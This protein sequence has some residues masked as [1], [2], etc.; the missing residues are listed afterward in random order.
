MH[1]RTR[2]RW[3]GIF[4]KL[5]AVGFLAAFIPWIALILLDAPILAPGGRLAP[6]LRFQPYNAP[7]EAMMAAV[8]IVWAVMLWRAAS[9]PEQ[10]TLFLDFTIWATLAHGLVM[11]IATPLQKGVGM[12]AIES[13]PLLVIAGLLWWLRPGAG[14]HRIPK[15]VDMKDYTP[16][17][18][19]GVQEVKGFCP[20][21]EKY[22]KEQLAARTI[23]VLSCEGPCIRGEIAR[24]AATMITQDVPGLARACHAET[25]FVPHSS[26]ATWVRRADKAVMIDG[27]FLKCH[28][29]VLKTLVP[30]DKVIHIDALP[31]Y[32]KYND[33]FL[34]DDVPEAE[35]KGVARQVADQII[36]NLRHAGHIPARA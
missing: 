14:A 8:Y 23:P 28:G 20:A 13:T 33:V 31:L 9:H 17:F 26:M 1:E 24:L 3:L 4:L 29:R 32:K 34:M 35:R 36:T 25:F 10:H 15:E 12:T 16:A 19:L 22:A 30:E 6:L 18:T 5:L 21:G 2:L 7:Y 27:C 11:V